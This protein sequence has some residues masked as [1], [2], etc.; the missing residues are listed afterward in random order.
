MNFGLFKEI[1]YG[2][3]AKS[4]R[5]QEEE[6]KQL[7]L[8]T[9]L[10]SLKGKDISEKTEVV[11]VCPDPEVQRE[12]DRPPETITQEFIDDDSLEPLDV[13]KLRTAL[14]TS[15]RVYDISNLVD[16]TI[17]G[18][19]IKT[20]NLEVD[21]NV[22]PNPDMGYNKK[23]PYLEFPGRADDDERFD[24][25]FRP[26]KDL[27]TDITTNEFFVS[28]EA[29]TN[30]IDLI[31]YMLNQGIQKYSKRKG[32]KPLDIIFIYKGGNALKTIFVKYMYETPGMITDRIYDIFHKYFKKSDADFQIYINPNIEQWQQVYD[33]MQ[34]LS[35][36]ILNRI[37]NI[38][39]LEPEKYFD[40]H[41]FNNNYIQRILFKYLDK[42][43]ND[44][45]I[46]EVV[47]NADTA[48][49]PDTAFLHRA[50][51]LG[52]R[53]Q[54]V[55]VKR[56][57]NID[58]LNIPM[59]EIYDNERIRNSYG[60]YSNYPYRTDMIIDEK[61]DKSAIV[62][63]KRNRIHM[64]QQKHGSLKF[65][66]DL[67]KRL[68]DDIPGTEMFISVNDS[69]EFKNG[70]FVIK[71]ALVRMKA[72]FSAFF[73]SGNGKYGM[74]NFPGELI[75]ISIAHRKATEMNQFYDS[76]NKY[77]SK[78]TYVGRFDLVKEFDFLSYSRL[79]YVKDLHKMLYREPKYPWFA[80]KSKKR[81]YRTMF[82]YY[83]ELFRTRAINVSRTILVE[84]LDLFQHAKGQNKEMFKEK[85][86]KLT[87]MKQQYKDLQMRF[88]ADKLLE[89]AGGPTPTGE[90]PMDYSDFNTNDSNFR[91][92]ADLMVE[93]LNKGLLIISSYQEFIERDGRVKA[94]RLHTIHTL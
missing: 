12:P 72:S 85:L 52:L 94:K 3:G 71:F 7:L 78:Y 51:F 23:K 15:D 13:Q 6:W 4:R 44:E 59:T 30:Y 2:G 28:E 93:I 18:F 16:A 42:L 38:F 34:A 55:M 25:K 86:E 27:M 22:L 10:K 33:D 31:F 46:K 1:Q 14:D 19:K 24:D 91:E 70:P 49:D 37:R 53:Y 57:R 32:L 36:L 74:L 26:F 82:L 79:Y 81:I 89:F 62:I 5:R 76:I 90:Y 54:N 17:D 45:K 61:P 64:D 9:T 84:F 68:F 63:Y 87:I 29:M 41:K 40:V 75:D 35:F 47:N 39:L 21:N 88:F 48:N 80:E 77:I 58:L 56:D 83:L 50:N 20:V 69:I 11:K 43:N 65:D 67:N 60:N 8:L 66:Y 73:R 92:F